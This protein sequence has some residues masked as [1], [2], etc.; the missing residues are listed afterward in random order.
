MIDVQLGQGDFREAGARARAKEA[1][2]VGDLRQADRDG[3]QRTRS[4]DEAC[5]VR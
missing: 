2:V 1:Q 4:L 5:G 3:L